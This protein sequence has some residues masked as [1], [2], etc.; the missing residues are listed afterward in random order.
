MV[1]F[2]EDV[3]SVDVLL[4]AI[5]KDPILNRHILAFTA[6]I[7]SLVKVDSP[8]LSPF[9]SPEIM[10]MIVDIALTNP[11]LHVSARAFSLLLELTL[12]SSSETE[13]D[14]IDDPLYQT[15]FRF[16]N[17][18]L[19]EFTDFLL[20][21]RPFF[22]DKATA[23]ELTVALLVGRGLVPEKVIDL[24]AG[25][26]NQ[27]LD[28][29]MNTFLQTSVRI[30]F[31]RIA[32]NRSQLLAFCQ[33]SKIHSILIE[34]FGNRESIEASYWGIL[35]LLATKVDEVADIG[36]VSGEWEA[37]YSEII[38]PMTQIIEEGYGGPILADSPDADE[39][40]LDF[41]IGKSQIAQGRAPSPPRPINKRPSY[42]E[43]DIAEEDDGE[44]HIPRK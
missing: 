15:V 19:S 2:L 33:T 32:F 6:T 11:D 10:D 35:Y 13:V 21:D 25:L 5:G 40:F 23:V 37:F 3:K 31:Q 28:R 36:E 7:I 34:T 17:S 8:L 44:D 43:E 22:D 14:S 30:L 24:A 4:N 41:P 29:P 9:E 1:T 39:E 42:D 18:K 27:L 38:R 20:T 26:F 16:L 12:H